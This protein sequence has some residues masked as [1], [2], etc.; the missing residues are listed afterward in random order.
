[1]TGP[2]FKILVKRVIVGIHF[3]KKMFR[4]TNKSLLEAK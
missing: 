2:V 1:M 3:T 4:A